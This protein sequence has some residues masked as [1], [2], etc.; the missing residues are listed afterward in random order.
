MPAALPRR[1]PVDPRPPGRLAPASARRT[2][3][4]RR[5]CR[6]G[7]RLRESNRHAK[8]PSAGDDDGARARLPRSASSPRCPPVRRFV[9]LM[10]LYLTDN[11]SPAEIA[12]AKAS[13]FVHAVKYYPAGRDD[14]FGCRRHRA[15]AR[16]SR[17]GGDAGARRRA[18]DARRSHGVRRRR[19]RS[20]ARLRRDLARRDRPRFSRAQDRARAH[21][22]RRGRRVR[23]RRARRASPRR[24]RRS[25]SS[26]RATR[27]SPAACARTSIACPS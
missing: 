9:P 20:R 10:T 2:R 13:G 7:R 8:P 17:A 4:G 5:A 12:A 11:T 18:V 15:R 3:H 14:P 16:L 1:S 25:I 24:S 26:I 6:H 19:L 27:S 23:R 22:D 21:H